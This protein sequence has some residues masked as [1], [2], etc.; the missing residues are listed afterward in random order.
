LLSQVWRYGVSEYKDILG[1][2][3]FYNRL[4]KLPIL[5]AGICS[6]A[7]N[8]ARACVILE[9]HNLLDKCRVKGLVF[10]SGWGSVAKIAST[11]MVSGLQKRLLQM[12]SSYY[13]TKDQI[14]L[15]NSIIYKSGIAFVRNIYD[16]VYRWIVKPL[17]LP[18]EKQ[19]NLF[20]AIAAISCPIL[21]IH[22]YEDTYADMSEVQKLASLSQNMHYWWIDK[23]TYH[24]SHHIKHAAV[25]KQ[26]LFEFIASCFK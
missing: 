14:I 10:D 21:F 23:D 20:S 1:G 9:K 16:I 17:V 11:I 2:V 12:L 26:K 25:Y 13:K 6:G 8:A 18:Y 24:A 4:N 19:T 3:A 22:S 15:K 7:F 5:I